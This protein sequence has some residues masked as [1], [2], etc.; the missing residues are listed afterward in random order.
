LKE[1][2]KE[3]GQKHRPSEPGAVKER[4]YAQDYLDDTINSGR[5]IAMRK[6]ILEG[7]RKFLEER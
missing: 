1:I 5:S 7:A 6:Q 3:D 4:Q 2:T